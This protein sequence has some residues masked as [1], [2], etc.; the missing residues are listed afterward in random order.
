MDHH[1]LDQNRDRFDGGENRLDVGR[2]CVSERNKRDS[3][4]SST[5]DSHDIIN[6]NGGMC[7]TD[8]VYKKSSL[9]KIVYLSFPSRL[10]LD[11]TPEY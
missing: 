9:S 8:R 10:P 11:S 3:S 6:D 1:Q 4:P 2:P 5:R 7:T